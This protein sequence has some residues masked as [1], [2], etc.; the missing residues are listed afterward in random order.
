MKKEKIWNILLATA[1]IVVGF[2]MRYAVTTSSQAQA[3]ETIP[4]QLIKVYET[5]L[6]YENL[7]D[8]TRK[9]TRICFL[10][11]VHEY[12][13]DWNS[14][15]ELFQVSLSYADDMR[16]NEAVLLVVYLNLQRDQ[17][18]FFYIYEEWLVQIEV[19]I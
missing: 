18:I 17:L 11:N 13:A 14:I 10:G 16:F 8:E 1:I 3:I 19:A 2:F 6:P 15:E 7:S 9:E 4:G 5:E 12:D